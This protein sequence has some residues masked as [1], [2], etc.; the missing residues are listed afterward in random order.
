MLSG[1][2]YSPIAHNV[3]IF[4]GIRQ[5]PGNLK[6]LTDAVTREIREILV[7]VLEMSID[8][9]QCLYNNMLRQQRPSTISFKIL[10]PKIE[11]N[12]STFLLP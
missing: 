4:M 10:F 6:T 8:D 11:E 12:F 9:F 7:T 2:F 1:Q 3:I 5:K